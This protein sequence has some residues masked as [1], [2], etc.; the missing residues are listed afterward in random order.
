MWLPSLACASPG[1]RTSGVQLPA[2]AVEA[3]CPAGSLGVNP[4][5]TSQPSVRTPRVPGWPGQSQAGPVPAAAVPLLLLRDIF[6]P[7]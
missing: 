6:T 5:L 1:F 3:G 2:S 7:D 4:A